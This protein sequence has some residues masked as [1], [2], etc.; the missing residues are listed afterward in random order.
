MLADDHGDFVCGDGCGT[1]MDKS[2]LAKLVGDD[3]LVGSPGVPYW[4]V[5]ALP[6]TA[7]FMCKL[8]LEDLYVTLGERVMPIGQC[9]DH[10]AWL[11][12]GTRADFEAGFAARIKAHA[13][14]PPPP[15]SDRARIE[16]LEIRVRKLEMLVARLAKLV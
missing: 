9:R 2:A 12:R 11:E 14:V 4:K 3:P 5:D 13:Y 6:A 1:W 15:G 10:G 8:A 16:K 7:C